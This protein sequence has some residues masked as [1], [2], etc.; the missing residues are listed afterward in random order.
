[1]AGEQIRAYMG[2]LKPGSIGYQFL[3]KML[4][5]LTGPSSFTPLEA[6]Q[7]TP[8]WNTI[9]KVLQIQNF[10]DSH[11]WDPTFNAQQYQIALQQANQELQNTP[12]ALPYYYQIVNPLAGINQRLFLDNG[13]DP[14]SF[15]TLG[16]L[17]QARQMSQE[18]A[19]N[20]DRVSPYQ[21]TAPGDT[22]SNTPT[23]SGYNAS[24]NQND[25][26][27]AW[28]SEMR[29]EALASGDTQRA[30]QIKQQIDALS[31]TPSTS[32]AYATPTN[33]TSAPVISK[34]GNVV[35]NYVMNN[36]PYNAHRTAFLN[37]LSNG[38]LSGDSTQRDIYTYLAQNPDKAKSF[39]EQIRQS[40][41]SLSAN[42]TPFSS[43]FGSF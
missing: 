28:L 3:Q 26:R 35:L 22:T 14:S 1:M 43:A 6:A 10:I 29:T 32:S 25:N 18:Y 41:P 21:P 12:G 33:T 23:T 15:N 7:R 16:E 20:P 17:Q 31:P 11:S 4:N 40:D 27:R 8:Y 34:D 38:T 13:I 42:P 2:Q 9:S 24:N 36:L 19:K 5:E 39:S 37:Y 30:D